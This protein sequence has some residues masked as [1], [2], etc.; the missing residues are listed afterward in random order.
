MATEKQRAREAILARLKS[1][2]PAERLDKSRRAIERLQNSD[3]FKR[4][5]V[6]LAYD[7][8]L[9]EVDTSQFLASCLSSGKT[10][11]LPRTNKTDCSLTIH[12]VT[13]LQRDLELCRLGF[14]EPKK[15]VAQIDGTQ[16]DFIIVPGLAFDLTGARLGRGKGYYDRFLARQEIRARTAAVAFEFQIVTDVPH[17]A[18]DLGVEFLATEDR[19]IDCRRP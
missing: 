18:H 10:L 3:L 19:W 1:M 14:R 15:D 4:S 13:D 2:D 5:T 17:E 12:R 9:T 8:S 7:S 16:I 6:V 11:C